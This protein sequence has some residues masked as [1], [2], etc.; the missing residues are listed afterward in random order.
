[1]LLDWMGKRLH[2]ALNCQKAWS[3]KISP[4]ELKS[5]VGGRGFN[6]KFFSENISFPISL[7]V[8]K[9]DHLFRETLSITFVP[10]SG[11]TSISA[12]SLSLTLRIVAM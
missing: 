12:L 7:F 2:I 10:C 5:W 11:W 4:E 8:K 6:V 3:E 9:S 1:M